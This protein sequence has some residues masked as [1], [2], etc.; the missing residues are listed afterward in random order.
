[1]KCILPM[2]AQSAIH[3]Q[4]TY[5]AVLLSSF[6][7]SVDACTMGECFVVSPAFKQ[8][9]KKLLYMAKHGSIRKLQSDPLPEVTKYIW[10]S[11][12]KQCNSIPVMLIYHIYVLYLAYNLDAIAKCYIWLLHLL[13]LRHYCSLC[14]IWSTSPPSFCST[15]SPCFENNCWKWV[16]R[17]SALRVVLE[18]HVD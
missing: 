3:F 17:V 11:Y 15:N 9:T 8:S 18:W 13:S 10:T 16:R 5:T 4:W 7:I 1:M 2:L 6:C 12:R 14:V